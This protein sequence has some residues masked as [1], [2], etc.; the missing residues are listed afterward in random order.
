[1]IFLYAYLT[2]IICHLIKTNCL[3]FSTEFG[4]AFAILV[5]SLLMAR[6][7]VL[8]YHFAKKATF[9]ISSV[10]L[11]CLWIS[12]EK[13]HLN[14]DFSWPWLNLGN[15]FSEYIRWIQWYEFTGAF[16][17]TLW[18]WAVNFLI[19]KSLVSYSENHNKK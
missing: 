11:T 9:F 2:F 7:F 12:F 3:W 15:G 19:F 5:N 18:V 14:W 8:Y 10:F 16:G 13:M 17:G 1:R 6:I 4:A